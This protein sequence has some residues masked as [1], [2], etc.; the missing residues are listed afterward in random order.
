MD[1]NWFRFGTFKHIIFGFVLDFFVARLSVAEG[2]F[3]VKKLCKS[4]LYMELS[5]LMSESCKK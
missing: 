5:V 1:W 4:L 3:G 2:Y